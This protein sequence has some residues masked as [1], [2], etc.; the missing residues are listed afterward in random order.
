VADDLSF[1]T[2]IFETPD[3]Q[4]VRLVYADWLEEQGDE[5]AELIRLRCELSSL[6]EGARGRKKL[7]RR[8]RELVACCD[9]EWLMLLERAD[10][11]LRYLALEPTKHHKRR[12][13]AK[14]QAAIGEALQAFEAELELKLPRSYKAYAHVFG[15][16]DMAGHFRICVPC[17]PRRDKFDELATFNREAHANFNEF[18]EGEREWIKRAIFFASTPAEHIAWNPAIVTDELTHESRI[19][20]LDRFFRIYRT[21]ETFPEFIDEVCLKV[22]DDAGKE[23]PQTFVPA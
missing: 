7:L 22:Y 9:E 14:K 6:P 10:W 8:E 2:Q 23:T 4:T 11:K 18:W 15:L 12:W 5:R 3:D 16:G 19:C 21:A 20:W 1:L 17:V 13:A